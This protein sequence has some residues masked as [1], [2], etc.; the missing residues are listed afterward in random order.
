[1]SPERARSLMW[2]GREVG[3]RFAQGALDFDEHRWRRA[4]VGYDHLDRTV[5]AVHH[6]WTS[7]FG[8]W[9]SSYLSHPRSYRRL[10]IAERRNIHDHLDALADL[11]DQFEPP[12]SDQAQNLP[13]SAGVL[14]IGPT[15]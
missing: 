9:L 3:R 8:A 15:H 12:V 13:R 11:D 5:R 1:M 2:R 14:R 4:L 6:T 7:G 10:T